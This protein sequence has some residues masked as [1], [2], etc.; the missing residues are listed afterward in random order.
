[1]S[2][3]IQGT[4]NGATATPVSILHIIVG[5][6]AAICVTSV[7]TMCAAGIIESVRYPSGMS[8]VTESH[9]KELALASLAS[10]GTLLVSTKAI[11]A[12]NVP[13]AAQTQSPSPTAQPPIA[14][15]GGTT[16]LQVKP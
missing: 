6:I 4:G 8:A 10:L 14:P 12:N 1:M 3:P 9:I 13:P 16:D 15:A 5:S 11:A 2:D 7:L